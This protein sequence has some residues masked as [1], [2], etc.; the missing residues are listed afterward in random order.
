VGPI[1]NGHE[2]EHN[3]AADWDAAPIYGQHPSPPHIYALGASS[4]STAY[5]CSGGGIPIRRIFMLWGSI[6]IRR[7]F[8]L[9]GRHPNLPHIYALGR[10]PNPPHSYALGAASQSAAYLCSGAASQSASY[11]CSG[12]GIPIRR[13]VML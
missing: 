11:L 5:L 9:W 12:G 6:P 13:T 3:C 2:S 10:H 7:I 4:Q 1:F 8:M